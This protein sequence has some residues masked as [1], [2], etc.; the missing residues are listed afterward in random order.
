MPLQE[1]TEATTPTTQLTGSIRGSESP[2]PFIPN[3]LSP[4]QACL[5]IHHH[6]TI[7]AAEA[8]KSPDGSKAVKNGGPVEEK[9]PFPFDRPCA[10][11]INSPLARIRA[12]SFIILASKPEQGTGEDV[13]LLFKLPRLLIGIRF[14]AVHFPLQPIE[15]RGFVSLE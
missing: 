11:H 4:R 1:N 2:A 8:E 5:L 9:R 10:G 12:P 3:D 13:T 6:P 14:P 15:K 7:R